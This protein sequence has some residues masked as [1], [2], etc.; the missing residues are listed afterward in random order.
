MNTESTVI[1]DGHVHL[2]PAY[3]LPAALN[4]LFTNLARCAPA[5]PG[6][7]R[8]GLLADTAACRAYR[9][10]IAQTRP[11]QVERFILQPTDE[12]AAMAIRDE[13]RL[14]G[15]LIA[16]RQIVT[17]EHLELLALSVDLDLPDGLPV[18][19]A[20]AAIHQAG[21]IPALAWSPGKWSGA[22]G[23]LVRELLESACPSGF[24]LGDTSL[25]PNSWPTPLLI[26]DGLTRGFR[27]LQGTDPLPFP[28]EEA[29]LGT[30]AT[31]IRGAWDAARPAMSVRRLLTDIAQRP[32]AAG[33]RLSLAGFAT[34][35]GR[36]MAR[37]YLRHG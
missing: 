17:A 5:T 20:L 11:K 29:R 13:D 25:R 15:Y 8:V 9:D 10:R 31:L 7:I 34:R 19:E 37:K 6:P 27:V 4:A 32:E 2:Y 33:R 18:R 21:G 36:M 14:L 26:R 30:C 23:R 22:R 24:L 28:G 16:G 35:W 12:P 3:R 1:L